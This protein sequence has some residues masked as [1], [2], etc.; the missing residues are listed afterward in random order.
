MERTKRLLVDRNI[1]IALIQ[2][3]Y[4]LGTGAPEMY[5]VPPGYT[6]YH[7]L[8]EHHSSGAAVIAKNTLRAKMCSYSRNDIAGVCLTTRESIKEAALHYLKR[9]FM[10]VAIP[11]DSIKVGK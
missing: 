2:E 6:A 8:T 4:A 11:T 1:D 10:T 5:G 3:P 9:S 7:N